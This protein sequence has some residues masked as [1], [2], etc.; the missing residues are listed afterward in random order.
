MPFHLYLS[1]PS[2]ILDI[3]IRYFCKFL[4]F[5][6]TVVIEIPFAIHTILLMCTYY[7]FAFNVSYANL[8]F[9]D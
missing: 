4:S 6:T 8:L 7:T 5:A 9:S 2:G 1:L 3:R